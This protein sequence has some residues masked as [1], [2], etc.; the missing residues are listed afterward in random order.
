M[1]ELITSTS[2][3]LLKHARRLRQ[4]KHRDAEGVFLVEGIAPTWQA[5][6]HADVEVLFYSPELLTSERALDLV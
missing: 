2:N 3:R 5:L 4:R 6:E 1:P